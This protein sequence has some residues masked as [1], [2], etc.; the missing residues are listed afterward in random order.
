MAEIYS[1]FTQANL[2]HRV[3]KNKEKQINATNNGGS[4]SKAPAVG[5]DIKDDIILIQFRIVSKESERNLNTIS[6]LNVPLSKA[7]DSNL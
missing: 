4:N 5:E 3:L 7:H 6:F 2:R 1:A